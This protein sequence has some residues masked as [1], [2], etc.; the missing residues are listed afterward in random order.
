MSVE[1][2]PILKESKIV[3][4]CTIIY[5][6]Q[7]YLNFLFLFIVSE[8]KLSSSGFSATGSSITSFSATVLFCQDFQNSSFHHLK[9]M[10]NFFF[11]ISKIFQLF[12]SRLSVLVSEFSSEIIR[13]LSS[14]T[15]VIKST[16]ST[17]PDKSKS[18]SLSKSCIKSTDNPKL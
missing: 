3:D 16:S 17:I 7:Y 18:D 4:V 6:P 10:E 8:S 12:L 13:L 11:F 15:L 9:K 14:F 2:K 1:A 5:I